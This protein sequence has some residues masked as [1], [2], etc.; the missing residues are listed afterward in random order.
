MAVTGKWFA[1][2]TGGF[3]VSFGFIFSCYGCDVSGLDCW[4]QWGRSS[5][6]GDGTD[7]VVVGAV[8][9]WNRM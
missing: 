1:G 2:S 7:G 4:C 3:E 9:T 6:V 5:R 8:G